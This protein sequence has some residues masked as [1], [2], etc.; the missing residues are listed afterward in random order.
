MAQNTPFEPL[1]G[2]TPDTLNPQFHYKNK[3]SHSVTP[4]AA[5]S[6]NW[7]GALDSGSFFCLSLNDC[8]IYPLVAYWLCSITKF[9]IV[10][11]GIYD[12]NLSDWNNKLGFHLI[13]RCQ[14]FEFAMGSL[15]FKEGLFLVCACSCNQFFF[16]FR[17]WFD[18]VDSI[19]TISSSGDMVAGL[20][21]GLYL[22]LKVFLSRPP[23]ITDTKICLV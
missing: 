1:R 16:Q 10:L 19:S 17:S 4:I 22:I 7:F 13:C 21:L 14:G 11:F 9:Y 20:H 15:K 12:N 2:S 3:R 23:F 8:V 5:I 18:N 6:I